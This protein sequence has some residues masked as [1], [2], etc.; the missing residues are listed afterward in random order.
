M[1]NCEKLYQYYQ[2]NPTASNPDVE[3]ALGW[4]SINVKRYKHRLK[5]RGLI[6]I[7]PGG[8]ETNLPFQDNEPESV[9]FKTE[10]YQQL[11]EACM[12]RMEIKD[13][14]DSAF[15]ELI[16]EARLILEKI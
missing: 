9:A 6:T 3:Q 2:D 8:I 4:D 13:L 16:R 12:H 1:T 11:Y 10:A 5:R 14:S 15:T 7:T